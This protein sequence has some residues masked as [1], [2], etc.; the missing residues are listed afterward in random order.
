MIFGIITGIIIAL[1]IYIYL[2]WQK[3]IEAD[4]FEWMDSE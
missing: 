3:A 1:M 2:K 4:A